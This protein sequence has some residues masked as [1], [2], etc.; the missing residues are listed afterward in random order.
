M[1]LAWEPWFWTSQGDHFRHHNWS[2]PGRPQ[3]GLQR[4]LRPWPGQPGARRGPRTALEC[5][6]TPHNI[7]SGPGM[8][9]FLHTGDHRE[10]VLLTDFY[11]SGTKSAHARTHARMHTHTHTHIHTHTH[12]YLHTY[13]LHLLFPYGG[14]EAALYHKGAPARPP[15]PPAGKTFT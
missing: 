1:V 12:T 8:D 6:L 7:V 11:H 9:I 10:K 3:D 4:D 15:P 2:I 13:I 5:C 14:G